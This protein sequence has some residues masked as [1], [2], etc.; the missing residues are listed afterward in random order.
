MAAYKI[1]TTLGGLTELSALTVPLPRPYAPFKRYAEVI[2]TQDSGA[3]GVGFPSCTWTFAKLTY[4]QVTQ[5]KTFCANASASIFI[6]TMNATGTFRQYSGK[7]KWP[8]EDN[9]PA[10]AG[11]VENLTITFRAL[12]D[13]TPS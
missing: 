1:G 3:L 2:D 12:V 11:N 10:T 8:V 5:L 6:E 9:T 4:A 13:V 7:M